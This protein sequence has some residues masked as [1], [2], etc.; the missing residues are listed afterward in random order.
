MDYE[1]KANILPHTHENDYLSILIQGTYAERGQRVWSRIS[2]GEI[3]Y[4]PAGYEHANDFQESGGR[5][6]NIEL[7]EDFARYFDCKVPEKFV[8][9]VSGSF[10]MLYQLYFATKN[11]L[12]DDSL[13]EYVLSFLQEVNEST[14]VQNAPGWVEKTK[15]ILENELDKFHSLEDLSER[16]HVHPVYLARAFKQR[17]GTTIGN[18]Q[19]RR[20]LEN[21]FK[22]LIETTDTISRVSHC[23]GFFDDAHFI[24][25]FKATYGMSP[26]QFR[27]RLKS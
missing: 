16:V 1:T 8:Q 23:N 15:R 18:Y 19:M 26:H 11:R 22:M 17:T 5:C 24:R 7:Q 2:P 12:E 14:K 21:A 27:L 3:L 6:F 13:E 10:P 4:R 9:F 25:S 20:K